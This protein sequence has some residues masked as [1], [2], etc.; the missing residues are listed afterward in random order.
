V[1]QYHATFR[2][3][4]WPESLQH[5]LEVLFSWIDSAPALVL[6][7]LAMFGLFYIAYRS[8]WA[9]QVKA[10][11]YLCAWLAVALATEVSLARPTFPQYFLLTVPYVAVLATAGLYAI[12]SRLS[13]RA[14][15][16]WPVTVVLTIAALGLGS[17]LYNLRGTSYWA[18]Y[19]RIAAKVEEVTPPSAPLFA[20]EPIY[21][22]TRRMPPPGYELYYTHK[23]NLP[24][25]DR[26]RLHLITE[27]EMKQQVQSGRFATAYT[28][29]EDTV[30]N[31]DLKTLYR[32]HVDIGDCG[33]FWGLAPLRPPERESVQ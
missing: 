24:A 30:E 14:R 7:L 3:A 12:G 1:V 10:E 15:P 29:D 18:Q 13:Q 22:L 2:N 21:F 11:F 31:Y 28:C 16:A 26:A 20:L 17:Y 33:V 9:R 23:V 32:Q 19:E 25:T 27:A 4:Y 5:D 8:T 6:G